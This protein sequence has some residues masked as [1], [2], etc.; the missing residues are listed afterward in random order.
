MLQTEKEF[1]IQQYYKVVADPS[2]IDASRQ[3]YSDPDADWAKEI[4]DRDYRIFHAIKAD[5]KALQDVFTYRV[6][7]QHG[8]ESNSDRELISDHYGKNLDFVHILDRH[9]H[10]FIQED[11]AWVQGLIRDRPRDIW[12]Q[13]ENLEDCFK[14]TPSGWN[15][16]SSKEP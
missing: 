9:S 15:I 2:P 10:L 16:N 14:V 5:E 7:V 12:E 1:I 6:I 11:R 8:V 3:S 13:L 4:M